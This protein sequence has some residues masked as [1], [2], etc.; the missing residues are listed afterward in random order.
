MIESLPPSDK[1]KTLRE[2][3]NFNEK[4]KMSD[5]I[6][7]Q[8]IYKADDDFQDFVS[9]HTDREVVTAKA[10]PLDPI[11][12]FCLPVQTRM[13]LGKIA[14]SF[15]KLFEKIFKAHNCLIENGITSAL[16]YRWHIK[17]FYETYE[18]QEHF[19]LFKSEFEKFAYKKKRSKSS[20]PELMKEF[21]AKLFEPISK[22]FNFT[23]CATHDIIREMYAN[24]C[25]I[26]FGL[27]LPQSIPTFMEKD[28][29]LL[30]IAES[31]LPLLDILDD[32]KSIHS[33]LSSSVRQNLIDDIFELRQYFFKGWDA[34]KH[35]FYHKNVIV[36]IELKSFTPEL[37]IL[38]SNNTPKTNYIDI[39]SVLLND[40]TY[41]S[42][43]ANAPYWFYGEVFDDEILLKAHE[44][45]V[46]L[47]A[48]TKI[49]QVKQKHA[50]FNNSVEDSYFIELTES[51][52]EL[53]TLEEKLKSASN[54]TDNIKL[55]STIKLSKFENLMLNHFGCS[56]SYGKG[57]EIKI[58][59]EGSRIMTIGRHKKDIELSPYKVKQ[60]LK[61]IDISVDEFVQRLQ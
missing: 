40:Q 12:P 24:F 56:F 2:V 42:T 51:Q 13:Y 60:I 53:H 14:Y 3:A 28:F 32:K 35:R 58:Q 54:T 16:E 7:K 10:L 6:S 33:T 31:S 20:A 25:I 8:L 5:K 48:K 45:L 34:T 49:G 57:S 46:A 39:D 27:P 18:V 22:S 17:H 4:L 41:V 43:L 47:F 55:F 52:K 38:P 61:R 59:R 23:L 11:L 30:D 26:Q 19:K 9:R 44:Y 29:N 1:T 37:M 50:N 21:D 36:Q 15:E